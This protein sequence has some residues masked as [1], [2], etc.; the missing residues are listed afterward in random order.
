MFCL[1][2]CKDEAACCLHFSHLQWI[3]ACFEQGFVLMS[4]LGPTWVWVESDKVFARDVVGPNYW[5]FSPEKFH[6]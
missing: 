3:F 5:V 2:Y 6:S 1:T 4:L